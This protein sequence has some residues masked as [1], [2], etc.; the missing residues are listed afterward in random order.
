MRGGGDDHVHRL[1][2]EGHVLDAGQVAGLVHG[3]VD[4][5]QGRAQ[6][7]AAAHQAGEQRE[8]AG[9]ELARR[10]GG[11]GGEGGAVFEGDKQLQAH[12]EHLRRLRPLRGAAEGGGEQQ[13][14]K[15]GLC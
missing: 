12:D 1:H 2:E 13:E 10:A 14:E 3:A 11:A 7:L 8:Q 9:D 4:L 6:L 5:L 15:S